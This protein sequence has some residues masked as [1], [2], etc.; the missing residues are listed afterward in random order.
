MENLD[1]ISLSEIN[2][3]ICTLLPALIEPS[4]NQVY[5]LEAGDLYLKFLNSTE[6]HLSLNIPFYDESLRENLSK[7]LHYIN[8]IHKLSQKDRQQPLTGMEL[9]DYFGYHSAG[10]YERSKESFSLSLTAIKSDRLNFEGGTSIRNDRFIPLFS[11][12][13]IENHETSIY[14]AYPLFSAIARAGLFAHPIHIDLDIDSVLILNN[15]M[16]WPGITF[17]AEPIK[18][19]AF[20]D[21]DDRDHL[22][23]SLID[24]EI[25]ATITIRYPYH[26]NIDPVVS[27]EMA[28]RSKMFEVKLASRFFYQDIEEDDLILLPLSLRKRA[29]T[30]SDTLLNL[31]R[32]EHT[33][34]SVQ[35]HKSL[36]NLRSSWLAAGLNP[37][38]YPF[39]S[40]WL[41]FIH[42]GEPKS[43]WISLLKTD[44][45]AIS[46]N[47]LANF[48]ETIML[49]YEL[50]WL[51]NNLTPE[52]EAVLLL[53]RMSGYPILLQS[54][55]A[56][57]NPHFK[58]V[59]DAQSYLSNQTNGGRVIL[60]DPFNKVLISNILFSDEQRTLEVVVPDLIY[61]AYQPFIG[62]YLAKY[63]YDALTKGA[64]VRY[65]LQTDQNQREWALLA[66]LIISKCEQETK[67]YLNKYQ[68]AAPPQELYL[69]EEDHFPHELQ[70]E[71]S[72]ERLA[73][74]S[75]QNISNS[76]EIFTSNGQ[77]QKLRPNTMAL[78]K[79][80]GEILQI[81]A[82]ALKQGQLFAA[83]TNLIHEIDS[84][85]IVD[86]LSKIS[87]QAK[88]WKQALFDASK[89]RK[90]LYKDLKNMGLSVKDVTFDSGYLDKKNHPNA[91]SL[92]RSRKDWQ[93]VGDFLSI[94]D[95]PSA[96]INHKGWS[97]LNTL[98]N[99]Y[100]QVVK[101]VLEYYTDDM[102]D[103]TE[104]IERVDMLFNQ[105]TE[106]RE[107]ISRQKRDTEEIIA[108][109]SSDI[110]FHEI[111]KIHYS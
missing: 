46:G 78:V 63:I 56:Y 105:T 18:S 37:Y 26:S 36:M 94:P 58:A 65:D 61:F 44:F 111:I 92:P 25:G 89:Q 3:V 5:L 104:L 22:L 84:E 62:Y 99:V 98:R 90:N 79:F 72:S 53:P 7:Y 32:V 106:R 57:L 77:S 23:E 47:L 11:K 15:N 17:L 27:R 96:W 82:S 75:T 64:R 88:N 59:E 66:N 40:R 103:H 74:N 33:Q 13:A 93:I 54:V 6:R 21:H 81:K 2:S 50:N 55:R 45:P 8:I 4:S 38:Q 95:I 43:F 49:V 52:K 24:R 42:R 34:H 109:I 108:K 35:L 71:E 100:T 60:L 69:P 12:G 10:N 30:L 102:A 85:A 16:P 91:F 28:T 86:K 14:Q 87:S 1:H 48:E 29:D 9:F 68:P 80:Q 110:T 97:N 19:S 76:I 41:M 107:D 51:G 83:S 39:P 70:K 101:L 73:N 31:Y 20:D 67:Q